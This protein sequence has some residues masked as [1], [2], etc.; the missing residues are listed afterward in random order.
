[1]IPTAKSPATR[2]T[3]R[4]VIEPPTTTAAVV[5]TTVTS[6]KQTKSSD[7]Y[8]TTQTTSI[9]TES[10]TNVSFAD[11]FF[12]PVCFLNYRF[13]KKFNCESISNCNN[14]GK[15]ISN[16]VCECFE[17]FVVDSTL[18]CRRKSNVADCS[19]VANCNGGGR[20]VG[21]A[22]KI[23]RCQCGTGFIDDNVVGC[24]QIS[25]SS[26]TTKSD[27]ISAITKSIQDGGFPI[28]AIVGS[29]GGALLL[30]TVI[31]LAIYF[32]NNKADDGKTAF[33]CCCCC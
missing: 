23:G 14:G 17:D 21:E 20:C 6:T 33:C 10:S 30:L 7:S 22:D 13:K 9:Q 2:A 31:V 3:S 24:R 8:S 11:R 28:G 25:T 1:M 5:T 12:L 15:C 32:K 16:H 27:S 29:V 18:G 4:V 26:G 19:R